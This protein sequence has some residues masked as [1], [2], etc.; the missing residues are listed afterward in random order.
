MSSY[1]NKRSDLSWRRFTNHTESYKVKRTI[2]S[3]LSPFDPKLFGLNIVL[4]A[5]ENHPAQAVTKT[6]ANQQ[7]PD[8]AM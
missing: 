2:Q 8:D 1:L 6:Q 4:E 7:T 5:F 3:T